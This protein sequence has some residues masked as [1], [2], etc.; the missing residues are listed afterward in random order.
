[1]KKK[2]KQHP[3]RTPARLGNP[4]RFRRTE[5]R[6]LMRAALDVGLPIGRVEVDPASGRISIIPGKAD[7]S[8]ESELDNWM[9]QHGAHSTERA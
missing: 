4:N 2:A 5:A 7:A 9:K 8:K 6:R 1:M 3:E